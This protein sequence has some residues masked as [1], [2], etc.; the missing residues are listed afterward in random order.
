MQTSQLTNE[1]QPANLDLPGTVDQLINEGQ[2]TN[3]DQPA[4]VDQLSDEG[5]F[6]LYWHTRNDSKVAVGFTDKFSYCS[7]IVNIGIYSQH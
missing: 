5:H 3:V 2:L 4:N 7:L 1:G 6:D